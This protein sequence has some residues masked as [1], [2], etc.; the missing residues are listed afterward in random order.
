MKSVLTLRSICFCSLLIFSFGLISCGLKVDHE[1][2]VKGDVSADVGDNVDNLVNNLRDGLVKSAEGFKSLGRNLNESINGALG[3]D[4]AKPINTNGLKESESF[5]VFLDNTK[6][7]GHALFLL[8]NPENAIP[9]DFEK[10]TLSTVKGEYLMIRNH[11]S[12]EQFHWWFEHPETKA[13][14]EVFLEP[15]FEKNQVEGFIRFLE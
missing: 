8:E 7:G 1:H 12:D 15:N 11:S 14:A 3:K 6:G 5:D 13:L 10:L 2:N 9:L 4:A